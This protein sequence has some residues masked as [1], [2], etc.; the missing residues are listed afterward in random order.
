[1]VKPLTIAESLAAATATKGPILR[2]LGKRA[3]AWL[4]RHRHPFNL[5]IHVIGIPMAV[6]GVVLVIALWERW[7]WGVGALVLGYVLQYIGHQ[8]EGNDVGEWAGIKKLLGLPYVGIS[9]RWEAEELGPPQ[10]SRSA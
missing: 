4:M 8:V 3:S 5:A 10:S 9:P 7:Y 1:M 6:S 2:F